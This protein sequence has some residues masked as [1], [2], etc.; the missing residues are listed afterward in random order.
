MVAF[1]P[2]RIAKLLGASVFAAGMLLASSSGFASPLPTPHAAVPAVTAAATGLA[3]KI[4]A[5][6]LIE[7]WT[8]LIKEASRKFGI[9]EDWIKAVMRV[10]SGGRA[11]ADGK[12][13]KSKA[14]AIGLMQVMPD[15]YQDMREQYG[16][17]ADPADPH[18]NVLAGAAY[19]SWLY[20]KY[21]YPKMFAAYNAGPG[22]VEAH[23]AGGR[24]LPNETRAYV[25]NIAHILGAD[26][27]QSAKDTKPAR[28]VETLVTLTRPNGVSFSI[29]GPTVDSI[30]AA[31]P[32]EYA[33]G[34]QTVLAIGKQ[35]QGVTEDV[36]T[37]TS[38][39]KSHG[40]KFSDRSLAV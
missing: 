2:P 20:G 34:V 21:G 16:L 25:R 10:E 7:H 37:V 5:T 40:G 31:L 26:A 32:D 24:Q 6:P 39:L 30:R 33:P 13:I 35:R 4:S 19:L 3:S 36:A 17:G 9:A 1:P 22:T 29:E 28:P 8:P 27:S 23:S 38:L 15:T 18:D 14:G 11:V 12:P